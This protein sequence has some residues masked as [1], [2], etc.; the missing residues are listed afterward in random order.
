MAEKLS[1]VQTTASDAEAAAFVRDCPRLLRDLPAYRGQS[2]FRPAPLKVGVIADAQDRAALRGAFELLP[3]G[4]DA[5]DAAFEGLDLVLCLSFSD[6]GGFGGTQG[7]ARAAE[8]LRRARAAG[9]PTAFWSLADP[10]GF[11]DFLPLAAEADLVFTVDGD[12]VDEYRSRLGREEVY[13]LDRGV[14]PARHNPLGLARRFSGAA[15][16]YARDAFLADPWAA[17][18][19]PSAGARRILK[20]LR[21]G[22]GAHRL[23]AVG[24]G[25]PRD[26]APGAAEGLSPEDAAAAQRLFRFAVVLNP[27]KGGACSR[28]ILEA[29]A[30]GCVVL[31]DYSPA[32][33]NGFPGVFIPSEAGEVGRIMDGYRED[34]LLSMGI[35]GVRR[36][37]SGNTICDRLGE[38]LSRAGLGDFFGPRPVQVVVDEVDGEARGWLEQQRCPGARLVAAE[39]ADGL[40]EGFAIRLG[41]SLPDSPGYLLDLVNAFKF[42]DGAW[43]ACGGPEGAY[44]PAQGSAPEGPAMV[45]LG[46]LPASALL[47]GGLPAD[48]EGIRIVEPRWGRDTSGSPKKLSVCFP[49][50][51]NG[52]FL[53]ERS[54]RSLLRSSVFDEMQIYL[55]DDGSTDG[56]TEQVVSWI[57]RSYDNVSARLFGDG[58]S[59]SPSRPRNEGMR[60]A[61]E[62]YL[63]FLDPDNE[64]TGDG[65][66]RL[67]A[68]A[69]RL[70]VD[71]AYGSW[72]KV[73]AGGAVKTLRFGPRGDREVADPAQELVDADF[74]V[75]NPQSCV[76]RRGLID[77]AGLSF[78]E[79]AIGED[80]L[81][82][83]ELLLR[84]ESAQAR[85]F[86]A[87]IYWADRSGSET[88]SVGPGFFRKSLIAH[89]KQA[90]LFREE[91]LLEEFRE[92]HLESHLDHWLLP[93]L[94]RV[95]LG[96]LPE[97][98]AVLRE[99]IGLYGDGEEVRGLEERR[100][101]DSRAAA[102]EEARRL[103]AAKA[104]SDREAERL[105]AQLADAREEE[106]RREEEIAAM[107]SSKTWKAGRALGWLPRKIGRASR[108][109]RE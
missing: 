81:F 3:L 44:E 48:A 18:G 85:S 91:G 94:E 66:A 102:E 8:V 1:T 32:V 70:G 26:C 86:A 12:R 108:R 78:V 49:I 55:V 80:T 98:S 65:Y 36:A 68:D 43:A 106:K 109:K 37:F 58:G 13:H 56:R 87:S 14:D 5:D 11:E 24:A 105:S 60:L 4:P 9:V 39:D 100:L 29:Q 79:G 53:W 21:A 83:Y 96:D 57:A 19:A 101:G 28:R 15:S 76:I 73:E 38:I 17:A 7:R 47:E 103:A 52:D 59:G 64:A 27:G 30:Q 71:V 97:A 31:S 67:L 25:L 107:R 6:G 99:I 35:E 50:H 46:K 74:K 88:N 72:L 92:R 82:G 90:E 41:P 20:G 10:A 104:A 42:S 84:A 95:P 22:K 75:L 40:G 33:S 45:D 89:E 34:E 51:N 77:D 2:Y 69:E 16:A 61:R 63:T 62:P 54:F 23:F 93:M